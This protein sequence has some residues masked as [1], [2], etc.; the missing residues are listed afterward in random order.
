MEI[1]KQIIDQAKAIDE[2]NGV[3]AKYNLNSNDAIDCL[4]IQIAQEFER[5]QFSQEDL[6][7]MHIKI[8][9]YL[10]GVIMKLGDK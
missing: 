9:C 10:L 4:M 5:K 2:I 3:I 6:K 1:S 8:S 7:N